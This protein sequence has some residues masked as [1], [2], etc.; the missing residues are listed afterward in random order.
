MCIH[1]EWPGLKRTLVYI[2]FLDVQRRCMF[3]FAADSFLNCHFPVLDVCPTVRT[4]RTSL[5]FV[6]LSKN[7]T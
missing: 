4:K 5:D 1:L 7:K 2:E 6:T 3:L